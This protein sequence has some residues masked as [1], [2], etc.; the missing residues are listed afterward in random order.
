MEDQIVNRVA[1]SPL[2]TIDLEEMHPKG[3]RVLYDLKDNLY[4]GLILREKDFRSFIKEHDWDQYA[5]KHVAITCTAD[6]IVPTWAYM[7]VATKLSPVAA[8][9]VFGDLARLEEV[10]YDKVISQLNIEDYKEKKVVIKGCSKIEVPKTAY[11]SIT[12]LLQPHV[13]KHHVRR[14]M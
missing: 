3:D 2:I 8:T 7:L 13:I 5:N 1:Q 10:L 12:S 9:V 11:V 6:A 4:E 14:A